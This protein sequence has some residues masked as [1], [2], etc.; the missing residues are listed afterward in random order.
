MEGC[1][2]LP[3]RSLAVVPAADVGTKTDGRREMLFG[4]LFASLFHA[5][6]FVFC[7]RA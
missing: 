1:S 7:T 5:A 3:L 6:D 2:A 4:F